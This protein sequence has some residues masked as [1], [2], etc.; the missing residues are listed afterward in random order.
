MQKTI[1]KIK[2]MHCV[3]CAGTIERAISKLPGVKLAQVNFAAETLSVDFDENKTGVDDFDKAVKS[4]GYRLLLPQGKTEQ[5][6]PPAP[7][8]D[9]SRHLGMIMPMAEGEEAG[10][11]LERE[12]RDREKELAGLK[13]KLVIGGALSLIIFLGS[14]PQWFPFVPKILNNNYLLL[15]LAAPVQFWVGW[16]FYSGLKI[17]FKYRAADMNTLIVIGTLSA[18]FYSAAVTFFP[19]FFTG[20][21]TEPRIYFD[22]S[23]IIITLI[24]LGRYLELLAKG[25]A[26]EAIKKLMKLSAKTAKIVRDGR[27]EE[28]PIENVKIGDIIIVRPGEKIPVDGEIVDGSSEIDES[29]LT[30]ES[31]PVSKKAG[32]KVI[33]ATINQLGSF[34]FK[35]TKVGKE[36][37]LAQIIKMVEQ[38][39]GSK[40][41]IQRLADIISGYFVP[42]VAG[43]AALT[44]II[45]LV[46]GPAPAFT[47]ALVNFVAVLI[48]ACPCALGLATPMA[49]MV[50]IGKSAEKGILIRDAASLEIARKINAII[51]D[52][53][54]TLTVGKPAVTDVVVL[55]SKGGITKENILH[56]AGSLEQRSEHSLSKAII[57]AAASLGQRSSH[58]LDIAIK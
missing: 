6:N 24:L 1:F 16:R 2:G 26:S 40:A 37:L 54:G 10:D 52:K 13:K 33:G 12:K 7:N 21:G 25:R 53:T 45:W 48:I 47:F 18:Y 50:G 42:A 44:F 4:T 8:G 15:I 31:M 56:I 35:A 49:M 28:I 29:M 58:A 19:G 51:L 30:G 27:E 5:K 43:T 11:A 34:K 20:S 46:F 55:S 3:S 23:A 14:F 39:Q 17:L 57:Q 22:T 36:T 38:A 41:P 9:H 32:D